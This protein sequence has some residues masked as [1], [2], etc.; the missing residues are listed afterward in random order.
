MFEGSASAS[1]L[2][3]RIEE[4][5]EYLFLYY[6]PPPLTLLS[7]DTT[8]VPGGRESLKPNDVVEITI[9]MIGTLRNTAVTLATQRRMG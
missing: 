5:V 7:T 6:T 4:L 9:D 2:R 8:I 1:A 3:R